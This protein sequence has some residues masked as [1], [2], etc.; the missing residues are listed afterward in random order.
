LAFFLSSR[1]KPVKLFYTD[2]SNNKSPTAFIE[3]LRFSGPETNSANF[4]TS[5]FKTGKNE[6]EVLNNEKSSL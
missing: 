3:I 6:E 4:P 5:E 2:T 1:E